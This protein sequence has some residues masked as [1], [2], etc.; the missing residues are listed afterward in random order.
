MTE[1]S[2]R[3]IIRTI[4]SK[5]MAQISKIL[6]IDFGGSKMGISIADI[7][8]KIAFAYT[9]LANDRFFQE[10]IKEIIK[11]ENVSLIVFGI[12]KYAKNENEL[13]I[14]NF[15]NNLK[16]NLKI[17]I[18]FEEEMF[19]SKMAQENIKLRGKKGAAKFDDAEAARIIL[20]SWLEKSVF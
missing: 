6:G 9:T 13:R 3:Y 15:A 7:E 16:N 20:Q 12:P 2:S 18:E 17:E 11:K 8:T 14:K 19:T 5:N 10:K 4:K 1:Q